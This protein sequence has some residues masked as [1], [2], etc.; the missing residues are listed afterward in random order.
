LVILRSFGKTYGMAGL[1]LGFALA[2]PDRAAS[3]RTALGPWAVSGPA[4]AIGQQALRDR[5]W[6][7]ATIERLIRTTRE[8]DTCLSQCGL[9]VVGGT[10]L[11]RLVDTENALAVFIRLGN[12][13]IFARRFKEQPRWLRFGQPGTAENMKRFRTALEG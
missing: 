5:A 3:I 9:S 7:A 12:A 2:A 11:F 10:R 6:K 13:G 4:I 1:R 8:L